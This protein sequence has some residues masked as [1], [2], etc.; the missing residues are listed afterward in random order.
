MEKLTFKELHDIM[1]GISQE[2]YCAQLTQIIS[3]N[4]D[5]WDDPHVIVLHMHMRNTANMVSESGGML[6]VCPH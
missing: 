4:W 6:I 5:N 3:D 1:G 2:E